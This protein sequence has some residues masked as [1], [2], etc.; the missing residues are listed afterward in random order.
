M[1]TQKGQNGAADV[2]FTDSPAT[3]RAEAATAGAAGTEAAA[4]AA[5]AGTEAATGATAPRTEAAA[6]AT[7]V[8]STMRAVL[9]ASCT[10]GFFV[11]T[12]SRP[13]ALRT[14]TG[15]TATATGTEAAASA[16]AATLVSGETFTRF[17]ELSVAA[18]GSRLGVAS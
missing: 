9:A 2:A 14:G 10:A 17:R 16:S 18:W 15:V 4:A 11:G 7:S 12:E 3:A 6:R 8:V 13:A 5:A 1:L